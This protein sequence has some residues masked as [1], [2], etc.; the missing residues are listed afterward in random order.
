M[1]IPRLFRNRRTDEQVVTGATRY[2][3][4]CQLL[5][6]QTFDFFVGVFSSAGASTSTLAKNEDRTNT[7]NSRLRCELLPTAI[8]HVFGESL[9]IRCDTG[10]C[11][12]W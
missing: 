11:D 4:P 7:H 10:G 12:E 2:Q 1:A 8:T 9:W 6:Y 5:G 3:R